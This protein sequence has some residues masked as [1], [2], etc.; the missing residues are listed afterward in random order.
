M[1]YGKKLIPGPG[2]AYDTFFKNICQYVN[3]K[4]NPPDAPQWSFIP[5]GEVEA[6]ND[7]YVPTLKPH[8]PAETAAW[9]RSKKV[10][11]RFIQVWF[12]G[13][14]E[15]VTE[16]DLRNMGI[17]PI[18]DIRTNV[19]PPEVQVEAVNQ[20]GR[21]AGLVHRSF[22]FTETPPVHQRRTALEATPSVAPKATGCV[23]FCG[24]EVR[25]AFKQPG[26]A[27]KLRLRYENRWGRSGRCCPPSFPDAA[28]HGMTA[29]WLPP[30]VSAFC[31]GWVQWCEEME[32]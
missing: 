14:P 6:L 16:E 5:S 20:S 25:P 3:A 32:C 24:F 21:D 12:R 23:E 2:A 18:D 17:P 9:K 1:A 19:P 27:A 31:G 29:V 13:F 28:H 10:L 8:T 11:S 4:C 22:G 30:K 7:A 15:R 26:T